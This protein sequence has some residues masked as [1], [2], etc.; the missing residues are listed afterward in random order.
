MTLLSALVAVGLSLGIG[1]DLPEADGAVWS[2]VEALSWIMGILGGAT[3]VISLRTDRTGTRETAGPLVRQRDP[4][5]VDREPQYDAL[6]GL[7]SREQPPGVVQVTGSAGVGKSKLVGS[8]LTDLGTHGTARTCFPHTIT[9]GSRFDVRTLIGNI[10]GKDH[11]VEIREGE[12]RL[13]SLRS[14]LQLAGLDRRVILIE[15]AEHLAVPGTDRRVDEQMDEALDAL[16]RY[17]HPHGTT[18]ILV[19]PDGIESPGKRGWTHEVI[20]VGT[21]AAEDFEEFV[22]RR[23]SRQLKKLSASRRQMLHQRLSGNPRNVLLMLAIVAHSRSGL[24]MSD[25]LD[26][27]GTLPPSS[28]P[29]RLA[30]LLV[31]ELRDDERDVLQTLAGFDTPI[32]AEAVAAVVGP[33]TDA[34]RARGFLQKF[35]EYELV[36][37]SGGQWSLTAGKAKWFLPTSTTEQSDLLRRVAAELKRRLVNDPRSLDDLRYSFAYVDVLLAARRYAVAV[38]A[39]QP[40]SA[41]LKRWHCNHLLLTQRETVQDNTGVAELEMVNDNELGDAYAL[42]GEYPK[43]D[44]AY[45]RALDQANRLGVPQIVASVQHNFGTYYW[46]SGRADR[47]YGY[48]ENARKAAEEHQLPAVLPVALQGLAECHRRWGEYNRA[49]ARA[50]E[51]LSHGEEPGFLLRVARWRAERGCTGRARE[52]IRRAEA[53]SHDSPWHLAACQEAYADLL[54]AENKPDEAAA[55]ATDALEKAVRTHNPVVIL[56]ARTTLTWAALQSRRWDEAAQHVEEAERYRARGS[57]L[58]VIALNALVHQEDDPAEA[59]RL[60]LELELESRPRTQ[61]K[62]DRGAREMLGI[63]LCREEVD[64]LTLIGYFDA[65]GASVLRARRNFLLKELNR[66]MT[67]PGRLTPLLDVLVD[68]RSPSTD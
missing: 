11:P 15:G 31:A 4:S 3:S 56:R 57:A 46:H 23:G 7:L 22:A 16:C 67:P 41:V 37:C 60:F 14:A 29:R 47:A 20:A 44:A 52:L 28:M 61:D 26:T 42:V 13:T 36:R 49:F 53:L 19:S 18:V 43:A 1:R 54:L 2:Y 30:D 12:T 55:S 64:P 63:A 59:A 21:L 10:L 17:P 45:G 5:L 48:Y 6:Y 35:E 65:S 68:V 51:V 34:A 50:D 25:L 27:V 8:V 66:R 9:P 33:P 62:K 40:M 24:S 32:D 39:M 38:A 58:V